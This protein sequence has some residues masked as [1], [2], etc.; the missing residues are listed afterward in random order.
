MS[1]TQRER[2]GAEIAERKGWGEVGG[3]LQY[4][5]EGLGVQWVLLVRVELYA[6]QALR[7]GAVQCSN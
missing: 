4:D 7:A 6:D 3:R 1:S 2:I 5:R